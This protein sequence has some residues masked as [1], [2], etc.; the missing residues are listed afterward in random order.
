[1]KINYLNS[2]ALVRHLMALD[3]MLIE[4]PGP[5]PFEV[6]NKLTRLEKRAHRLTTM[7]CDRNLN[8]S[9]QKELDRIE[10]KVKA[11]FKPEFSNR[12]FI[13]MDCRGYAL[14]IRGTKSES[15]PDEIPGLW[16]DWGKYGI[17]A[18]EF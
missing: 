12:I 15:I 13:N 1:M 4:S 14:K 17:L 8:Q 16:F 6:Y 10:S 18:P 3:K 2:L 5:Y 9:E 11:M 7:D